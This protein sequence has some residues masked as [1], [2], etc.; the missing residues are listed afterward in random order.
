MA[1]SGW[2]WHLFAAPAI[3]LARLRGVP[4]LVNYRGGD[5]ER[6]LVCSVQASAVESDCRCVGQTGPCSLEASLV[7]EAVAK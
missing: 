3:W 7:S 2:S 4:V 6:F 1:N 5:A